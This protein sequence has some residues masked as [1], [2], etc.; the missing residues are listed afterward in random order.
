MSPSTQRQQAALTCLII[1][2]TVM[3]ASLYAGV[4]PH[5]PA[6]T[7]LFAIGPFLAASLS[8]AAAALILGP[9]RSWAGRVLAG[10][11]AVGA[12]VSFGP[13]K[14]LDPEFRQIWPAVVAGQVAAA[15][16]LFGVLASLRLSR[17]TPEDTAH[18][19]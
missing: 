14:Y 16:V 17:S 3:L 7:P 11:A 10:L 19:G 4:A 12:L 6:R 15:M 2:Q 9:G 5:P 18:V 8:A 13:Q 1:L